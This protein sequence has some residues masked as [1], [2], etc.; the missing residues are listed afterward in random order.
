[1]P[2]TLILFRHGELEER[3]QNRFIGSTDAPLSREGKKQI[4]KFQPFLSGHKEALYL[5]SPLKRAHDSFLLATQGLTVQS[6]AEDGL[7][8]INFGDWEELSFT[9][10][11]KLFP[12]E[13]EN[14][15][16]W[17][18]DFV[19]PGGEGHRSFT[20]RIKICADY[21]RGLE[22]ETVIAFTHG[23]VIMFMLCELLGL[24]PPNYRSFRV[25]RG[26]RTTIS[27]SNGQGVLEEINYLP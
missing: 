6:Q 1:M 27:L 15:A 2:N 18:P 10:I 4:E 23:G 5:Y 19:Y 12:K 17:N 11:Q 8:E 22:N 13:Y 9:D 20:Q 3:F 7:R 24:E 16:Q 21:I 25:R 26:S 14:W